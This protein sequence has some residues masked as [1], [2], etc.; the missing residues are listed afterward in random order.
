MVG[1]AEHLSIF[2]FFLASLQVVI[3]TRLKIEIFTHDKRIRRE[4][5]DSRSSY[6]VV[7]RADGACTDYAKVDDTKNLTYPS[8]FENL[9]KPWEVNSKTTVARS[10]TVT[11]GIKKFFIFKVPG[12][13]GVT[14]E[15]VLNTLEQHG[16]LSFPYGGS[17]RDQFLNA[18]PNDLDMETNCDNETI[19]RIC[20]DAWGEENCDGSKTSGIVHIGNITIGGGETDVIDA[21][22]WSE[23]F[24]GSGVALEYTTNSLAYFSGGL[25]IVIDLTGYGINDTCHKKIRIPVGEDMRYEWANYKGDTIKV[26]RYWKLR[27]KGYNPVDMSTK[28]YIVSEA[29]SRILN[30]NKTFKSFYCSNALGGKWNSKEKICEIQQENCAAALR[31]KDGYDTKFK[32]DLDQFWNSTAEKVVS[33]LGCGSCKSSNG[34]WKDLCSSPVSSS[35]STHAPLL[36]LLPTLL[37]VVMQIKDF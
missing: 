14:I 16:C 37:A 32:D 36:M 21:S 6:A 7:K 4:L 19:L 13:V 26:Y 23:T 25:D 28:N 30:N 35:V 2:L 20:K 18:I 3:S 29:M 12:L 10:P 17:V 34:E 11:T 15:G 31:K 22:V 1:T 24:F 8:G 27:V 5:D 33:K 9:T